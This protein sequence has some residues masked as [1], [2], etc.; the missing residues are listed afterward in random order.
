MAYPIFDETMVDLNWLEVEKAG[1]AHYPVLLPV[2]VIEEH[3]PHM[4]LAPDVYLT[5]KLVKS[6][7]QALADIHIPSL[8]APPFYWGINRCTGRFPGSFNVREETMIML[9]TDIISSLKDW[10]F[11]HVFIC[12]LHGDGFH[13][14]ALLKAAKL[15]S[16]DLGV[17]V[18][19]I[20]DAD[21]L[22]VYGINPQNERVVVFKCE[23]SEEDL[24]EYSYSDYADVHAG[25]SETSCMLKD[26]PASVQ[27]DL[28][29]ELKDSCVGYEQLENWFDDNARVL[30]PLGYCGNPA[31]INMQDVA[32]WD[33]LIPKA[34]AL[35]ISKYLESIK[36]S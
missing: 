4:D 13:I 18:Q 21:L 15:I 7:K 5:H 6:C 34:I 14:A 26:F 35:Q 20:F 24:I 30:T 2:S 28:L 11:R 29:S 33:A 22:H 27:S 25:G 23:G 8:I 10:G 32:R 31:H 1:K 12:N 9:L 16:K 3:G 36:N 19:F 17:D